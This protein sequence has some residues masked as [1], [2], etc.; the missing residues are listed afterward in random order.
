MAEE[1]DTTGSVR[2]ECT[3][4]VEKPDGKRILG[5]SG[6]RREDNSYMVHKDVR[7]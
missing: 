7:A 1:Y 6:H 2:N 5:R 4:L 3:S